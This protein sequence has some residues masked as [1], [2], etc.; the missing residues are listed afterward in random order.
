MENKRRSRS[1]TENIQVE[2][3]KMIRS[4]VENIEK[5]NKR[6]SLFDMEMITRMK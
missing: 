5:E 2:K 3:Y 6:R 4:S 1:R